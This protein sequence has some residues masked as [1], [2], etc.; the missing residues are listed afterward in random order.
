MQ[1][2]LIGLSESH[3]FIAKTEPYS[4]FGSEPFRGVGSVLSAGLGNR[5]GLVR[6]CEEPL[7][8]EGKH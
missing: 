1:G 3:K 7:G 5:E 8:L 4:A 6:V 2:D